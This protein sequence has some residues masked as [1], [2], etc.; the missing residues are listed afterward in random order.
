MISSRLYALDGVE[1][2]DCFRKAFN[3]AIQQQRDD[4]VSP[5]KLPQ[6]LKTQS[7]LISC[8]ELSEES[9]HTIRSGFVE[10]YQG[11]EVPYDSEDMMS[12]K[13]EDMKKYLSQR[14]NCYRVSSTSAPYFIQKLI[15]KKN[16]LLVAAAIEVM[17]EKSYQVD[18]RFNAFDL[19]YCLE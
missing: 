5:A 19:N 17:I 2:S 3:E 10:F 9:Y 11:R 13:L 8:N 15:K 14:I 6:E 7:T 1:F 12:A 18:K 4:L 16:E